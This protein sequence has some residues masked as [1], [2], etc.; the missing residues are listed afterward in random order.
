MIRFVSLSGHGA[1]S[2]THLMSNKQFEKFMLVLD[3]ARYVSDYYYYYYYCHYYYYR[4]L[5]LLSSLLLSLL[6][7][8][9]LLFFYS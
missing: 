5:L 2:I 3:S 9:L 1:S 6:L 4:Y 8:L 7:L